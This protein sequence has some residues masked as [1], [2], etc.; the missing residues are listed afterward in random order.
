MLL[1]RSKFYACLDVDRAIRN[2]N[3]FRAVEVSRISSKQ[4][5]TA[6]AATSFLFSK[7]RWNSE[8][9]VLAAHYSHSGLF[10]VIL[11]TAGR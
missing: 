11:I 2:V 5:I 9:K 4:E 3:Y 10:L 8:R 7:I 6:G 1:N